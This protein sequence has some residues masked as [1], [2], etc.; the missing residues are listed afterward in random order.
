[1]INLVTANG[2]SDEDEREGTVHVSSWAKQCGGLVSCSHTPLNGKA[3]P[4]WEARRAGVAL[5][6]S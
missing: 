3:V 1:M 2:H 5:L 4:C 6:N